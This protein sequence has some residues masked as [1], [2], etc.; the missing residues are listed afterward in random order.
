MLLRARECSKQHHIIQQYHD[1]EPPSPFYSSDGGEEGIVNLPG[2][3][4]SRGEE[5]RTSFNSPLLYHNFQFIYDDDDDDDEYLELRM[6]KR[7][8]RGK[9]EREMEI[10]YC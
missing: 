8:G 7:R 4:H 1:H 5:W 6:D 2:H 10:N 3:G 9:L